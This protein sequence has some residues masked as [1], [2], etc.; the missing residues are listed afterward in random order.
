MGEVSALV[1]DVRP[2]RSIVEGMIREAG[3]CLNRGFG[4]LS[5]NV[6][7]GYLERGGEVNY[8]TC[9]KASERWKMHRIPGFW[10]MESKDG[11]TLW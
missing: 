7:N 10:T 9:S 1:R 6:G 5:G 8:K 11:M 4:Y 2:A 3:E